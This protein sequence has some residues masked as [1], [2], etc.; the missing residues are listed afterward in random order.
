LGTNGSDPGLTFNFNGT[1]ATISMTS[2]QE[3]AKW[4]WYR[5]PSGGAVISM[6]LDASNQLI[7]YNTA[8]TTAGITLN[9]AGTSAFVNGITVGGSAVLTQ[10]SGDS[11]Y[12]A[13]AGSTAYSTATAVG[14]G[15]GAHAPGDY[16]AAFGSHSFANE[17]W[18][19]AFG[20]E[21]YADGYYSS[22]LGYGART[23]GNFAVALGQTKA[24]GMGQVTV[25]RFN[26]IQ[27]N[28]GSWVTSDDL[29]IV[30]NGTA[31]NARSNAF[32]V[33]KNGDTSTSGSLKVATSLTTGNLTSATGNYS[34]AL[35]DRTTASGH[36]STAIGQYSTAVG[37]S[38]FA[39]NGG[40]Y[41]N[42]YCSAAFGN[43]TQAN[44][45]YSFATGTA[46]KANGINQVVVGEYNALLGTAGAATSTANDAFFIVG[47]GNSDTDRKNA[48]VVKKNGDAIF[49]GT[50]RVPPRGDVS[51][52]EFTAEP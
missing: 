34:S 46:T 25:G 21:T 48:F 19:S 31:D 7:L 33:K 24:Q 20:N 44:G 11:R 3:A 38:A 16:S 35:G 28:S 47:N 32:V 9:P 41:A 36:F 26:V 40:A 45:H 30:G 4:A 27:G 10:S 51:M 14:S 6:K 12:V 1:T 8:G 23:T 39:A 49:T 50:V 52:G 15:D 29:F 5:T 37:M 2:S 13:K 22:A 43:W 17:G 18:S 42:G